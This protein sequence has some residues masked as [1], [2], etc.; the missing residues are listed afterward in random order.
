MKFRGSEKRLSN[1]VWDLHYV[2][3]L[4]RERNTCKGQSGNLNLLCKF[5]EIAI[6]IFT[7]SYDK[8]T[9]IPAFNELEFQTAVFLEDE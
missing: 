6:R 2:I 8:T 5:T 3:E 7:I 1:I 9:E 4:T